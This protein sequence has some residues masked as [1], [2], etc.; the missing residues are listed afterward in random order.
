MYSIFA[1]VSAEYSPSFPNMTAG[2]AF[3]KRL[4]EAFT[5]AFAISL[6][7]NLFIFPMTCRGIF[8]QQSAGM[9]RILQ[10]A[11]QAQK[12]Y[13][14]SL[15]TDDMFSDPEIHDADEHKPKA[16]PKGS[17]QAAAMKATI[18][19]MGE[20]Q[21]KMY[22]DIS[23][24]KRELAY[25]K[26]NAHAIETINSHIRQVM[27][28]LYG[29]SSLTDIFS[30]VAQRRGWAKK[31][32]LQGVT[33]SKK[34]DP[35]H[36]AKRDTVHQWNEVMKTLHEPFESMTG[37]M[38]DGLQH[39]SLV[40]ELSKPKKPSKRDG[41]SKVTEDV[42]AAAGSTKPGDSQFCQHLRERTDAFYEKR[43]ATLDIFLEKMGTD[44]EANSADILSSLE[45]EKLESH[46]STQR[47]LYM[48]LYMEFLMWSTGRAIFRFVEYAD[49]LVADGTMKK[50]RIIHPG[51]RRLQKWISGLLKKEDMSSTEQTPDATEGGSSGIYT[52]ASF[53]RKLDPEHLPPANAWE[54]FTNGLRGV[55][56]VLGSPESAFGF[57]VACAT[58]SIGIICYLEK[59]Q[60]FFQDQ[61][62]VWAMI[63]IAIGMTMTAGIGVFGFLGR[64][65][66]SFLAMCTSIVIWYIVNGHPAGVIVFF[67]VFTFAEFY[68]FIT[69][70]K[71][72]VVT[73]LSIVT[74]V[75]IVGYELQVEKV[76]VKVATSNGQPYYHIYLLAPYRLATVASGMVVAF[77]W[78]FFPYPL[79][80]RSQ[81]RKDLGSALYLLANFYSVVHTS[82]TM[83]V[84]GNEGDLNDKSSPGHKLDKARREI[85]EKEMALIGSLHQH[86]AFTV[87]EPTFGGK[88][89]K[90]TYDAIID[91]VSSLLNYLSLIAY[92][93]RTFSSQDDSSSTKQGPT[94]TND[95]ATT[96]DNT[97]KWAADF[98]RL[99]AAI[100]PTSQALTSTLALLSGAIAQGSPLPP[101]LKVP[102]PYMLS[103]RLK[104]L[105]GGILGVEHV[106]EPGYAAFAVMQIASSL[107]KDD[108]ADL[109][110]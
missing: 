67:F 8:F 75:L 109:I 74:Q 42:E 7:V 54:R 50:N 63:M 2:I 83:R 41:T 94:A 17:P 73:L 104:A 61:R 66:G 59:T 101:Y 30:R 21:G 39:V 5:L 37:L 48:V 52:G 93:S 38:C 15:E 1:M 33:P 3:V 45:G 96:D 106:L 88:F 57:R 56:K 12:G 55:G 22:A 43:R 95:Q 53:Q 84:G 20:L 46:R 49:G 34:E 81:L 24:A 13:V 99:I 26:L 87:F 47:K 72:M 40:L 103:A 64:I 69:Y 4:L 28:P 60:A 108:L 89:P 23:F 100:N 110:E 11:L 105:D 70:P 62:L 32:G 92:A 31:E 58:L 78:T 82:V 27:L 18:K 19:A 102:D 90:K 6:G 25:G 107:V 91:K 29:M 71:A 86:S 9:L 80:E 68:V 14:Q 77:F 76:G 35:N 36:E 85:W 16:K 98:T 10:G 65:I 44:F 79:T 97:Q 51:G